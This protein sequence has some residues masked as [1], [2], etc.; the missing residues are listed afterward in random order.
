[1]TTPTPP[2]GESPRQERRDFVRAFAE[3]MWVRPGTDR[4]TVRPQTVLTVA[5]LAALVALLVGV[6]W[7]FLSPTPTVALPPPPSPPATAY[8]VVSGWDCSAN[9]DHGFD[10]NGRTAAW[11]TVARGGWGQDGCHGSFQAIPMSGDASKDDADQF[12][13][14]WFTPGP[15]YSRCDLSVYVPQSERPHD[16]GAKAAQ[17]FVLAG[18]SGSPLAQFVLDQTT[19]AGRWVP[20]GKYPSG[21]DGLAIRVVNRGVPGTADA[22]LAVAQAKISC[23]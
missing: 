6:G 20:A 17:Y 11:Y 8:A 19:A 9:N 7:E 23:S 10:V 18:R 2:A 21:P 15:G 16:V 4:I 13:M 3:H 22:R 5:A 1:M 12:A 14:W